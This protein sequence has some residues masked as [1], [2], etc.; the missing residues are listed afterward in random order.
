MGIEGENAGADA[1]EDI[2]GVGGREK[3]ALYT[4]SWVFGSS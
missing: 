1:D 2:L 4:Q 3:D